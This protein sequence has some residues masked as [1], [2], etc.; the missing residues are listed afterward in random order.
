MC[1][2]CLNPSF[3]IAF[4]ITSKPP[5]SR[6]DFV[7]LDNHTTICVE[8]FALHTGTSRQRQ[9]HYIQPYPPHWQRTQRYLSN[10][11]ACV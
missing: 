3:S 7:L 2:L 1:S 5:S 4:L 10:S 8:M 6:M 11:S 9:E